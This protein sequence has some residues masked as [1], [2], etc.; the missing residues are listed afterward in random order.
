MVTKL[1]LTKRAD[2][3]LSGIPKTVEIL[4]IEDIDFKIYSNSIRKLTNL[5]ELVINNANI[6]EIAD[7]F[8]ELTNLKI[9]NLSRNNIVDFRWLSG[10]LK[11]TLMDLDLSHNKLTLFP[12][13]I[14][15][16]QKLQSLNLSDNLLQ[17]LP[18]A[19]QLL[20]LVKY[21]NVSNNQIT[22][23]PITILNLPLNTFDISK[24]PLNHPNILNSCPETVS[25]K[26]LKELSAISV[27]ENTI[28]SKQR[29]LLPETVKNYLNSAMLCTCGRRVIDTFYSQVHLLDF[30]NFP[31]RT[32]II[33]GIGMTNVPMMRFLCSKKC[34]KNMTFSS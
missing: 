5:T 13:N 2:I 29:N 23:F 22:Y 30:M 33:Y 34:L 11:S 31:K 12:S 21:V 15:K 9:C 14:L 26:S 7:Q 10:H 6:T 16:L 18:R 27:L 20:H 3:P 19:I 17:T 1:L 28:S 4:R 8:R 32:R 24:N 25:V